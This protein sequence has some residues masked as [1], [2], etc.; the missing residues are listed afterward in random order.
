GQNLLSAQFTVQLVQPVLDERPRDALNEA[1]VHLPQ[2]PGDHRATLV[3]QH[4]LLARRLQPEGRLAG[5][6]ARRAGYLPMQTAGVRRVALQHA[7]QRVEH[8]GHRRNADAHP[9][10][11][12]AGS[13]LLDVLAAGDHARERNRVE[14][15]RPDALR[16]RVERAGI[17]Q[18]QHS[19]PLSGYLTGLRRQPMPSIS[20]S[21]TS[22]G[23][24]KTGGFMNTPTPSGVPVLIMSPGSSVQV[25]EMYSMR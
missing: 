3:G 5:D 22:P 19:A 15:A 10:P 20:T 12:L 18:M 24:R 1:G 21:T 23:F 4:G 7:D 8:P 14:D 17:A 9:A 11:V 25:R 6:H 16:R 13:N 2:R